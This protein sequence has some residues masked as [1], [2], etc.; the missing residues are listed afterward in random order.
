M[1][2]SKIYIRQLSTKFGAKMGRGSGHIE[3]RCYLQ[4]LRMLSGGY[5][6]WGAYWGI[7]DPVW[8]CQ[9]GEGS[10]LFVRAS[11]RQLAKIE[12]LNSGLANNIIF[13]RE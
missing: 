1:A 4:K 9:D 7:G 6:A 10:Q 11:S 3:G 13:W 8:V 12:V 5:D 2:H